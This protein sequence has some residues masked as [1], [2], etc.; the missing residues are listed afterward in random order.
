MLCPFCRNE[1]VPD[2]DHLQPLLTA[3][4]IA[5]KQEIL[6]RKGVQM[7]GRGLFLPGTKKVYD[8]TGGAAV[9]DFLVYIALRQPPARFRIQMQDIGMLF[10]ADVRRSRSCWLLIVLSHLRPCNFA[11]AALA[12]D[13]AEPE[14][15][16][17]GPHFECGHGSNCV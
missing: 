3:L 5:L 13:Q 14:T 16:H 15:L 10:C 9:R 2:T 4:D 8:I 12:W 6:N 7:Y 1:T 17:G 11:C